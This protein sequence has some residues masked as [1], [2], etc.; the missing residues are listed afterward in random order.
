MVYGR[1][2]IFLGKKIKKA[3]LKTEQARKVDYQ[4]KWH[5]PFESMGCMDSFKEAKK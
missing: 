1:W 5:Y 3:G 4:S 2:N